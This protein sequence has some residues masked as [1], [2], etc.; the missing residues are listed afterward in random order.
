MDSLTGMMHRLPLI[1]EPESQ[2]KPDIK[3]LLANVLHQSYFNGPC[4]SDIAMTPTIKV[5]IS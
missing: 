5:N 1:Q 3:D 4:F 2:K